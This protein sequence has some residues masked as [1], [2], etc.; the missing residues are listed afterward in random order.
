M[1]SSVDCLDYIVQ[2]VGPPRLRQPVRHL[3]SRH[4]KPRFKEAER[5]V[6]QL[7]PD[8]KISS[9]LELAAVDDLRLDSRADGAGGGTEG[10]N[11]LHDRH[12]LGVSDLAED[13]VLAVEP[14]GDDGG[15]E[16]LGAVAATRGTMSVSIPRGVVN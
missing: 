3:H 2:K 1:T 9:S 10:L 13:D 11:L 15:D 5:L 14:R 4:E 6:I 7:Q 16:E 12:G 8:T